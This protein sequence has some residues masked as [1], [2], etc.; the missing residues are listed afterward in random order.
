LYGIIRDTIFKMIDN[1]FC[2]V[3]VGIVE[4]GVVE[5]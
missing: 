1:F 2:E 3:F 4:I 5:V